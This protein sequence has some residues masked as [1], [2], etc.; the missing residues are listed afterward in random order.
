M[1]STN[2]TEQSGVIGGRPVKRWARPP[3]LTFNNEN[4][5]PP[6]IS[7]ARNA[8][9]RAMTMGAGVLRNQASLAATAKVVED[10]GS[11][12]AAGTG[13]AAWEL[14]NLVAVASALL[15]AA[16]ARTESRGAHTRDDY[17]GT[18]PDFVCRLVLR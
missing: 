16:S 6:E 3:E 2:G 15:A 11:V 1:R 14:A 9:Q 17:P 10:A 5:T 12:A 8:L 18:D 4:S 13:P 7:A